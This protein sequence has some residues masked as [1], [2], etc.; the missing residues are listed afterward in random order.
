MS[1]AKRP[2]LHARGEHR[3]IVSSSVVTGQGFRAAASG[4]DGLHMDWERGTLGGRGLARLAR[5]V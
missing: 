2:R 1:V 4:L 5:F 3:S